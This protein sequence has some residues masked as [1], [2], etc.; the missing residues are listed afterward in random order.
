MQD[1]GMLLVVAHQTQHENLRGHC[2][3]S[4]PLHPNQTTVWTN[5][6]H[7][8]YLDNLEASFVKQLH[9]SVS[10]HGCHPRKEM[11]EPCAT[12]QLPAK[13]HSFSCQFSVLQDGCSQ[14]T[15]YQSNDPLFESTAD[16]CDI[17][18]SP[19]LHHFKCTGKSSS[20]TFP[21]P[22]E[23]V[24]QNDG[25]Y[26]RSNNM[27]FFFKSAGSSE[28][29]PIYQ[30]NN[31]NLGSCIAEVSDQNFVDEDEGRQTSSVSW[32]KRLKTKAVLD[33][34]SSSQ[35]VYLHP[36][37]CHYSPNVNSILIQGGCSEF[38]AKPKSVS[39]ELWGICIDTE[40][41]NP[42]LRVKIE[43]KIRAHNAFHGKIEEVTKLSI[44]DNKIWKGK[45]E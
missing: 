39:G 28:K 17:V 33:T 26:M 37:H 36:K 4:F 20:E 43:I 25:I 8:S 6:K 15:K 19:R 32:A 22:R 5:E 38:R 27:N 44:E 35:L 24:V 13:G 10:S 2:N 34:S 31:H 40:V 45:N 18:G 14:K 16:S 23:T 12:L 30:S 41:I 29:H 21:V 1:R 42:R 7:N 11:W 3:P 9:S